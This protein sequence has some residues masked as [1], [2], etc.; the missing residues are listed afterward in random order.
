MKKKQANILFATLTSVTLVIAGCGGGGG[1]GDSPATAAPAPAPTTTPPTAIAGS[2]ASSSGSTGVYTK[3]G[4]SYALTPASGSSAKL[5]ALPN[6]GSAVGVLTVANVS[7]TPI[8]TSLPAIDG[9]SV[10]PVNN[11]GMAYA[12]SSGTIS[13]FGLPSH[14][15]KPNAEI[16]TYDTQTVNTGNYSGGSVK[17]AGAVMNTANKTL[18]IATA[19][20]F[21]MVDYSNPAAL[22]K[23][24][25]VPSLVVNPTTGVEVMENFAFD[26]KLPVAGTDYAMIITGG[27]E[28]S[29]TNPV[30]T[31][32][33]ANTGKVYKP[34]TATS[35]LFTTTQ[36]ID[37]AA[38]DTTYHVAVLADESAGT[39]FVDLTKLTLNATAGT[40]TLPSAAVNRITTYIKYDNLAIESTKHLV[41]MGRGM[42]GTSMVVGLLKDPA[43][44]LGFSKEVIVN[45]PAGTD[46]TGAPVYWSG[47]GDPH[48]AGAYI[49]DPSH[50]T[51][52]TQTALG[53]WVNMAGTHIAI[54]D[55]QGVLDGTLAGG[56]Y[57]PT[58]TTPK[59]IV[60]FKIP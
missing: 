15:T 51:Y 52:T 54:I 31:L 49:T 11:V 25:E 36:Y 4:A 9:T 46:H 33:D 56:T 41:M 50:P 48:G 19:D 2:S 38:V 18:V 23:L 34:D 44:G 26:P 24:R 14:P 47:G 28:H 12:Y 40:Y 60:Y 30:M 21:E 6:T 37:S 5:L 7:S 42:G 59:D 53:L 16:S 29:Q 27:R 3:D 1:G 32:V 57:N 43:V 45:M 20:G 22:T 58:T 35:A 10:D 8:S 13:I 55:L 17:I 39:T